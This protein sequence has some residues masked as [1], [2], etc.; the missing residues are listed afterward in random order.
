M[1][2]NL[3]F[4]ILLRDGKGKGLVMA[5]KLDKTKAKQIHGDLYYLDYAWILEGK[6]V[7]I[8]PLNGTGLP[9]N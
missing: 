2:M 6:R 8:K 1:R 5:E 4:E 3:F 9:G 7:D